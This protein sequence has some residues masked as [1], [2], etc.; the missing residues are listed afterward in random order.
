MNP[1]VT[2][3]YESEERWKDIMLFLREIV[4]TTELT[5]EKKW[6]Q[7]CYCL[8]WKNVFI[9]SGFKPHAAISFFKGSLI[10]DPKNL[11]TIP[12]EHTKW[13]RQMRFTELSHAKAVKDD[14][15]NYIQ[16]AIEI[17]KSGKQ[18]EFTTLEELEVPEELTQIF[19]TDRALQDAFESLTLGRQKAYIM[20]F[21][22]A[23]QS[24]TRKNRIKKYIPRILDG[25]GM[26]DCVCGH[27]KKMPSCDG[28]HKYI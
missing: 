4:L 2:K 25:K 17:E 21:S 19:E 11:L 3:I 27:S 26:H 28:S 16:Q 23:K 7:A 24:E 8:E 1:E 18:V 14:I 20:F 9:I 6:W 15:K 12:G 10:Q 13:T 22:G 5:E